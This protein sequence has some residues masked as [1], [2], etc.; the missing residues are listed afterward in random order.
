MNPR[1]PLLSAFLILSVAIRAPAAEPWQVDA[2]IAMGKIRP[3]HGVNN[4]PLNQ[5]ETV[6]VS[7]AWNRLGIPLTRL[8]DSEWPTGDLVDIHAIVPNLQADLDSP[9]SYRFGRTDDYLKPI[10]ASGSKIVYRLG[11]SIEHSRRKLHVHPPQDYDCWVNACL[12]IIRH[13]NEGWADGHR[14]DIQY[15]EIWNEPENR[16]AMWSGTD[17][18]YFKLYV[19]A[20]RKIKTRFPHLKIGGPACGAV[21]EIKA[22]KLAP[23]PFVSGFLTACRAADA[24]LDFFS[25]HTYTNDPGLYARKAVAIRDWLN[26]EGFSKTELHLNEWNYLPGD[27]WG[28]MLNSAEP[29]ARKRWYAEMGGVSG[30]SFVASTL[31]SLQDSPVDIANYYSG[32]TSPFGVFDRFG[33]PKKTYYALLA[34]RQMLET[35]NR[36]LIVGDDSG[37]VFALAGLNDRKTE[38]RV[39]ISH[40]VADSN[41]WPLQINKLPWDTDSDIEV[42]HLGQDS[43]LKAVSRSA[44]KS[45][46]LPMIYQLPGSGVVLLKLRPRTDH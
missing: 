22:G 4:G 15:W 38:L 16:P 39:L 21:G 44:L 23:S 14:Y 43:D 5:G 12:G 33:A 11:E 31:I 17:E 29:S 2:T 36:V 10:L 8:H 34:F 13:Y 6:D 40:Q 3:L 9:A 26:R 7:S 1:T 46:G 35:P 37:K 32:D 20:A 19:T 18:E 28:P 24:P 42:L 45:G 25:W 41:S 27:D 30:A